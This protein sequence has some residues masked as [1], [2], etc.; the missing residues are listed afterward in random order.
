MVEIP[1][2]SSGAAWK[3][4]TVRLVAPPTTSAKSSN[5]KSARATAPVYAKKLAPRRVGVKTLLYSR[6]HKSDAVS[7]NAVIQLQILG[8][9]PETWA[10]SEPPGIYRPNFHRLQPNVF[11]LRRSK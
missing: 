3:L 8:R 4:P 11:H 6:P 2:N 7:P 5:L 9:P 1:T 10:D